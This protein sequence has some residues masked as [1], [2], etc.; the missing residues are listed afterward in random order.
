MKKIRVEYF[1]L[2]TIFTE[3]YLFIASKYDWNFNLLRDFKY[4]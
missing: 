2:N 1:S 4:N 3:E